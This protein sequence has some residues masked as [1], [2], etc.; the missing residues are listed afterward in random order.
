MS[1]KQHRPGKGCFFYG[2]LT[3]IVILVASAIGTYF[4]TRKAVQLA[5][6]N[7]LQTSPMTLPKSALSDAERREAIARFE[8]AFDAS[9]K[10]RP[11][12]PLELSIDELNAALAS[13][14]VLGPLK[15]QAYL[16]METNQL[17]ADISIP[18]DQF[19]IWKGLGQKLF[20]KNDGRY[21]NGTAFLDLKVVE[22]I[23]DLKV[24]ELLVNGKPLP[25]TFMATLRTENLAAKANENGEV[26]NLL[27]QVQK[28]EIRDNRIIL[29]LKQPAKEQVI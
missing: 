7:Y 22:G 6:E 4:G 8:N 5:M 1:D 14:G 21:L 3:F 13:T 19:G 25:G 18:L 20:L 11:T 10:G 17:K 26:R 24:T 2:C 9:Q 27:Q 23:L 12:P 29:H 16:R 15:D 28:V